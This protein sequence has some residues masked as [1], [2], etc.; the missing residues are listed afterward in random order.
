MEAINMTDA[1][2]REAASIHIDFEMA[3]EIIVRGGF[4]DGLRE[5]AWREYEYEMLRE[6]QLMQQ[7]SQ[8]EEA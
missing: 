6:E 2:L 3:V 8:L 5:A 1:E 7:E 4:C